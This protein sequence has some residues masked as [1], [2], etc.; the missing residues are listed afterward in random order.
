MPNGRNIKRAKK[1]TTNAHERAKDFLRDAEIE[2]IL[3]A[4]K[5]TRYPKRNYLLLL[6]IYRHGLQVSEATAIKKSDVNIQESRIWVNRLKS[7]LSVEHPISEDVLSAIKRFLNSRKDNLPW[8]FVNERGLPLS[9][10]AV[11][12]IVKVAAI[13]AKLENVHPHTLRHSC[14][15][16]LTNKGY[17]LRLIQDYLGHSDPKHTAHYT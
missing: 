1:E 3:E 17:D 6:T 4:S 12:Y 5:K 13:K 8:L 2:L 16:Y 10:H 7:G 15:F 14:G 11:N 9:R